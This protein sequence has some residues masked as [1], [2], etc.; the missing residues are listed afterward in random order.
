MFVNENYQDRLY[1]LKLSKEFLAIDAEMSDLINK[2]DPLAKDGIGKESWERYKE[3]EQIRFQKAKNLF[4]GNKSDEMYDD[5]HDAILSGDDG[6]VSMPNGYAAT[7]IASYYNSVMKYYNTIAVIKTPN[8]TEYLID[9]PTFSKIKIGT[10]YS[11]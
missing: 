7:I 9:V 2:S 10:I 4:I 11:N 8:N 6:V 3:L 1:I 5:I